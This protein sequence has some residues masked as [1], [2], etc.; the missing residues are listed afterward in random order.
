MGLNRDFIGREFGPEVHSINKFEVMAYASAIGAE[1]LNYLDSDG[2]ADIVPPSFCVTYELPLIY[3]LL[4]DPDLHGGEEERQKNMLMLVHG[5][6]HM[7]FYN[8]LKPDDK[9]TYRAKITDIEER[10]SGEIVRINVLS[11]Y[12]GGTKMVESD[13]GLFI[14]G[15]G[16][17]KRPPKK[18]EQKVFE[19]GTALFNKAFRVPIDITYKYSKASNDMNPIHLD[20][21]V[22]KNAGLDGI[23]VHGMCT[24]SMAMQVIIEANLGGDSSRLLSLGARFSAPV[25]PGDELVV[26]G[27]ENAG[28]GSITKLGFDVVRKSDGKKVIKDGKA[29]TRR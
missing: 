21:E 3:K 1:Y 16:S 7:K 2:N 27:R 24:M 10:G 28:Y 8:P 6:Q 14:R 13:W 4:S 11:A 20:D 17:G 23:V 19:H 26:E 9:I 18:R 12:G 25:Y 5:D 15:A 29:Q 22:A